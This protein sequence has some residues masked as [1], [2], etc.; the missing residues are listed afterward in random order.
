MAIVLNPNEVPS[1]YDYYK[2]PHHSKV[3]SGT[4]YGRHNQHIGT[5]KP[6]NYV[7]ELVELRK[8]AQNRNDITEG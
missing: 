8:A 2:Y 1:A 7:N 6:E 5:L 4:L 3:L